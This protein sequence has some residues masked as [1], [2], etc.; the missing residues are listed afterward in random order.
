MKLVKRRTC[1]A[2][3]LRVVD[4]N[5]RE[6][7]PVGSNTIE[8]F[9]G[10]I[11]CATSEPLDKMVE[12]N[13]PEFS[14]ELFTRITEGGIIKLTPLR[15]RKEDIVSLAEH[16]IKKFFSKHGTV[17]KNLSQEAKQLL[18]KYEWPGNARE[19]E[20][21]IKQA[22]SLSDNNELSPDDFDEITRKVVSDS[23]EFTSGLHEK[24]LAQLPP[25]IFVIKTKHM[26][27][28]ALMRKTDL[29]RIL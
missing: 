29:I 10:R 16:L 1:I 19:L 15:E 13:P 14:K 27:I 26:R 21:K 24:N 22:L 11:I 9:T 8:K 2:N 4:P 25:E 3:F 7:K 6:F 20:N 17:G 23:N 28:T 5:I 18:E 12:A